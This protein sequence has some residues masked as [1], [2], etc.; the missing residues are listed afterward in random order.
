MAETVNI[1]QAKSTLSRLIARV[2]SGEEVVIARSGRPVARLV[3]FTGSM[4][5]REGGQ[6]RGRVRIGRDF[7]ELDE[8]ITRLFE[9]EP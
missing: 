4:T 6:W 1:H 5:P 2:E 7:D 9:G 3:P 8:Q